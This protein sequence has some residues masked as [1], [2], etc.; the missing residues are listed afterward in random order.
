MLVPVEILAMDGMVEVGAESM[1][2]VISVEAT[3]TGCQV[4][5]KKRQVVLQGP[6]HREWEDEVNGVGG[7]PWS[8]CDGLKK[9]MRL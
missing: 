2:A 9:R 4:Q 8:G 3:I 7:I 1:V 5:E 6:W